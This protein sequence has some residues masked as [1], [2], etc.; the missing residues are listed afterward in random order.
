VNDHLAH[1]TPPRPH[2]VG[3]AGGADPWT[4]LV[5]PTAVPH[6]VSGEQKRREPGRRTCRG[7]RQRRTP[8]RTSA[9]LE[10]IN[11]EIK[12]RSRVVGIFLPP[13]RHR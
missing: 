8:T 5:D 2:I 3:G 9:S 7:P 6:R 10:R 4:A 1:V 13:T 12:R 11:K